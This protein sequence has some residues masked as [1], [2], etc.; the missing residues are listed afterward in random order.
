[1]RLVTVAESLDGMKREDAA[2]IASV[3]P[4]TVQDWIARFNARGVAGLRRKPVD[5]RPR[6]LSRASI[7]ELKA[8]IARP[9]DPLIDGA[10]HWTATALCRVVE[11]KF[12][13]RY[14][15]SGMRRLLRS[16]GCTSSATGWTLGSDK[17]C[18]A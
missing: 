5:G 3:L 18:A 9:P 6:K 14:G 12:G 15:E 4:E 1:M 7:A 11:A 10:E 2:S 16:L 17:P 13:A 8:I